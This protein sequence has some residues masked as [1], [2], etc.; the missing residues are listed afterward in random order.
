[1]ICHN[2]LP[3]IGCTQQNI[4]HSDTQ[5]VLWSVLENASFMF[6]IFIPSVIILFYVVSFKGV[7]RFDARQLIVD[8]LVE[9]KLFRGKKSH[10]MTLP[11]CR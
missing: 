7:K 3:V 2:T 4:K 5:L 6:E 8:A 11:V 10:A 9:K 1:M